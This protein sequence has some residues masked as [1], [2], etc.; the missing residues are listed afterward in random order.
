[1]TL[2]APTVIHAFGPTAIQSH[3]SEIH[4]YLICT[5]N[6]AAARWV[7]EVKTRGASRKPSNPIAPN[8]RRFPIA[9]T[10]SLPERVCWTISR[11]P[12]CQKKLNDDANS[13]VRAIAQLFSASGKAR[14]QIFPAQRHISRTCLV[15]D[16]F[17]PV[18]LTGIDEI[19]DLS[20]IHYCHP[21]QICNI[22]TKHIIACRISDPCH[23]KS[24]PQVDRNISH[25]SA[26][27]S[28]PMIKIKIIRPANYPVLPA[29]RKKTLIAGR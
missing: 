1:M 17:S 28:R 16:V 6:P 25:L 27:S 11:N 18:S 26:S 4:Q 19:Q 12:C 13:K 9:Q 23:K 3:Y 22:S 20:F 8:R 7:Q 5:V 29:I 24:T 14:S 10:P 21:T 15:F 2:L